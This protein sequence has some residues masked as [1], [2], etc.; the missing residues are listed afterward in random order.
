MAPK[1]T[2]AKATAS[3]NHKAGA[4][5]K[6]VAKA[7]ARKKPAR[8]K[9][10]RFKPFSSGGAGLEVSITSPIHLG[11]VTPLNIAASGWV[12]GSPDSVTGWL[13][14]GGNNIPAN[15]PVSVTGTSWSMTFPNMPPGVYA[16][17]VRA[18]VTPSG[19]TLHTALDQILI[20]VG[21]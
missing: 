21:F 1:K 10:P 2:P 16:L 17:F 6:A 3:G 20:T 18:S 13:V 9:R 7:P 8:K 5:K 4:R 14:V 12:S 15:M 11:K 19:G